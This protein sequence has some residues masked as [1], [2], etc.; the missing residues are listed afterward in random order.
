[1]KQGNML[2][3]VQTI[4]IDL[5]DKSHQLCMLDE[6]G[7]VVMEGAVPNTMHALE[8][9]FSAL[10]RSLVVLEAGTHS[11]WVSAALASWG[12]EVLVANPR[13]L[14]AISDSQQ[15]SDRHDARLLA[16]LA[17]ADR[18]LLSPIRHRG[19]GTQA[20]LALIK[21]RH[22]LV[23]SRSMLVNHCGGITKSLGGRLPPCSAESFHKQQEAV[24]VELREAL[25]PVIRAIAETTTKIRQLER[26]IEALA[27]EKYPESQKLT[28]PVGVGLLTALAF[29]LVLEDPARFAKSRQVGPYLGLSPARDQSGEVDKQL[30]IT[31][32][33]DGYLRALLVQCAHHVLSK[34]SKPCELKTWGLK[35]AERG[36][37]AAKKRAVVAVAR[38]L[39]VQMHR[40]WIG[41]EPYDA[42]YATKRREEEAKN[43]E[44]LKERTITRRRPPLNKRRLKTARSL[45]TATTG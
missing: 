18:A 8:K 7:Q 37:K 6:A 5:G 9:M 27:E 45:P 30:H 40:L 21:A 32:A 36:G 34:R 26:K 3:L 1:M 38:R 16:R 13:K 33:G 43:K 28:Q 25:E 10:P 2:A 39:A 12:H 17:R 24:P 22:A 19:A 14:R 20:D 35:L 4:G 23:R 11:P 15:K 31:K 42:F 44:A 29:M 41:G